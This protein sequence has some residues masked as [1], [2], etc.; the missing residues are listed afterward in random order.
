[1]VSQKCAVFIGPHRSKVRSVLQ[2]ER[3][4]NIISVTRMLIF[5]CHRRVPAEFFTIIIYTDEQ[6]DRIF[7]INLRDVRLI[8][9]IQR[10]SILYRLC[11][12]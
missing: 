7:D 4:Q 3:H 12:P 11:F 8:K 10:I 5:S 2:F 1:M 6:T 9:F